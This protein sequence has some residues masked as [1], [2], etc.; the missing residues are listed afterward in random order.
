MG[1]RGGGI[2]V[3]KI[4]RQKRGKRRRSPLVWVEVPFLFFSQIMKRNTRWL[5]MLDFLPGLVLFVFLW[6]EIIILWGWGGIL[7]NMGRDNHFYKIDNHI[8]DNIGFFYARCAARVATI[9]ILLTQAW[10]IIGP[11]QLSLKWFSEQ[12][13]LRR[14]PSWKTTLQEDELK[15]WKAESNKTNSA[16]KAKQMAKE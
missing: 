5:M 13:M 1:G 11:V 10:T 2:Q 4:R 15:G 12:K 14:Y 16:S 9:T 6:A 7:H 8:L 3:G